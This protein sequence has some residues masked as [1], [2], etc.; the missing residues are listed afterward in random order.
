M[1]EKHTVPVRLSHDTR[2]GMAEFDGAMVAGCHQVNKVDPLGSE[3]G[4]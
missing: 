3:S 2:P 1:E 4:F